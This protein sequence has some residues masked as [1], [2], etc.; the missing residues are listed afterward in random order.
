MTWQM[1]KTALPLRKRT[2]SSK[3]EKIDFITL[4]FISEVN[5]K[6]REKI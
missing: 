2:G 1:P 4:F 5:E 3:L 6:E